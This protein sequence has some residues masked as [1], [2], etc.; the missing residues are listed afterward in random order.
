MML[1][2]LP[3]IPLALLLF[4]CEVLIKTEEE[5]ACYGREGSEDYLTLI[6]FTGSK[7]LTLQDSSKV[8]FTIF[9]YSN[10]VADA[11]AT[12]LLEEVHPL[13]ALDNQFLLGFSKEA[14]EKVEYKSD[15]DGEFGYYIT[16]KVD[17]NNDG[18]IDNR[19][20]RQDFNTTPTNFMDESNVGVTDI[21]FALMPYD[22]DVSQ[23]F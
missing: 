11:P 9:G 18:I 12:T 5:S 3:A 2:L 16:I 4:S 8:K 23:P 13:S 14:F 21:T 15:T 10:H 1:K 22:S 19:D 7:S 6:N 17:S 20:Y